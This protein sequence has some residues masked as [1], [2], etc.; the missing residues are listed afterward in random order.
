[1]RVFEVPVNISPVYKQFLIYLFFFKNNTY[2]HIH[3]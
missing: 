2:I 1:M 3:V